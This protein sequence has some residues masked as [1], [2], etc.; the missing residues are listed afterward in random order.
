MDFRNKYQLLEKLIADCTGLGLNSRLPTDYFNAAFADLKTYPF[1]LFDRLFCSLHGTNLQDVSVSQ[2]GLFMNLMFLLHNLD[3]LVRGQ[4][5]IRLLHELNLAEMPGR[6]VILA[7]RSANLPEKPNIEYLGRVQH[8]DYLEL[9]R[10]SRL[11]LFANPTYP[12]V[13]NER[14]PVSL[15]AGCAVVCDAIP[16][17]AG[18]PANEAVFISRGKMPLSDIAQIAS[19]GF[20][21]RIRKSRKRIEKYPT[22]DDALYCLFKTLLKDS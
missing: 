8:A 1:E 18:F 5:R 16:S 22:Q 17:L 10:D 6:I 21:E 15:E 2:H 12:N 4:R 19:V 20:D 14:I 11:H 3:M 7:D 13:V 9:L